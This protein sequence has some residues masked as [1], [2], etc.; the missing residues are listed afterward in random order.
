MSKKTNKQKKTVVL[1][2][3]TLVNVFTSTSSSVLRICSIPAPAIQ[4]PPLQIHRTSFLGDSEARHSNSAEFRTE[5]T[6]SHAPKQQQQ[7]N[8]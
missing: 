7:H 4:S 6:G 8:N 1:I 5:Q 2:G 3:F